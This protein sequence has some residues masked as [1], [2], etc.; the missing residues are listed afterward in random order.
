VNNNYYYHNP[1]CG[2]G[3]VHNFFFGILR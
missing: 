2:Y 1:N 3:G